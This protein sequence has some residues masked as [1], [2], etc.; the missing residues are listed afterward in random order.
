MNYELANAEQVAAAAGATRA[1]GARTRLLGPWYRPLPRWLCVWSAGVPVRACGVRCL[2]TARGTR[3]VSVK[4]LTSAKV[5]AGRPVTSERAA[6]NVRGSES[7]DDG[8][9]TYPPY[10]LC[11][12]LVSHVILR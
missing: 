4:Y 12:V 6:Q 9:I 7:S 8:I 3:G 1:A 10:V 5:E 11:A 2:C